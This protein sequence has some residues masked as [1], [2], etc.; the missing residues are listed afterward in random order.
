MLTKQEMR[1]WIADA[2]RYDPVMSPEGTQVFKEQYRAMQEWQRDNGDEK[3][4]PLTNRARN[5]VVMIA[6]SVARMHRTD[7]ITGEHVKIALDIFTKSLKSCGFATSKEKEAK[8]VKT[9]RLG[10]LQ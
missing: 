1:I 3:E 7:I 5:D 4:S 8:E 10:D 9:M 6:Y 2:Q